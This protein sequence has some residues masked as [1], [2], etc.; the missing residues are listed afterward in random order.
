[1]RVFKGTYPYVGG[2][3]KYLVIVDQNLPA[4]MISPSILAKCKLN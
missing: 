2:H 4:V 1:M 3:R